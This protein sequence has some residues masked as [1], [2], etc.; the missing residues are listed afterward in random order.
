MKQEEID[1]LMLKIDKKC[2]FPK[3]WENFINENS[4]ITTLLSKIRKWKIILH[5][6]S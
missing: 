6:L 2:K 3:Y 5:K 1:K 4:K